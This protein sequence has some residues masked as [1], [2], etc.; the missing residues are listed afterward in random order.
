MAGGQWQTQN[1]IRP[2]VYVN[3]NSEP[4][5]VGT[6]GDRGVAALPLPLPWGEDG[7]IVLDN[8]TYQTD[9]LQK[10]G[11]HPADPRIRHITSCMAHVKRLLLYRLDGQEA[12]AATITHELLTVTALYGGKRGNDLKVVI[13]PSIDHEEKFDVYTFLENEEVDRQTIK[14][15]DELVPNAFVSFLGEGVPEPTAGINLSGGSD[16]EVTA[17]H[18]S[19]A[20]TAFEAQEFHTLGI[21]SDET[22]VK[23]LAASFVKRVRDE[24]GKRVNVV[25]AQYPEANYEG[26]I[27]LKNSIITDDDL[28]VDSIY[29]LCEITGMVAAAQINQ[30]LTYATI[31]GAVDVVPRFTNTEIEQALLNGELVLTAEGGRVFI[32]QDINTFTSFTTSKGKMFSKN[33]VV[34]VL[35]GIAND[36]K[37]IF[38]QFYIGKVDN[39]EDGRN[40]L[41]A[42]MIRYLETLQG[43]SAIQNFDAQTDL[44]VAAG[45]DIESVY[46]ELY[47]QPVDSIEKIYMKVTAR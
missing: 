18:Y 33:R 43:M 3:V 27:S 32:E 14:N 20:L 35:D 12:A 46:V 26:V 39:N 30:S 2:G 47:V 8:D 10:I 19:A 7:V 40:L 9:A 44:T 13:Q 17:G 25:L 6:V 15:I 21:P 36:A 45:N 24:S 31:P 4:R 41:K 34:R 16:G 29:L 23:A 42:E 22:E 11:F 38:E 5:P 37:R 28:E 1:K